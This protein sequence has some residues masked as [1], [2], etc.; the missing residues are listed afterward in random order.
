M[1]AIL[2][3]LATA[4]T[5]AL[6]ASCAAE[7]PRSLSEVTV[8]PNVAY[9]RDSGLALTMDVY[10]PARPNGAAVIWVN[11]GGFISGQIVQYESRPGPRY[12][13]LEAEEMVLI[14]QT[15]HIAL[16]E[17]FTFEN[18]LK[19]GFTVFDVCH[20]SSPRFNLGEITEHITRAVR[21][22][23]LRAT[24]FGI[25]PERIG[26][27]GAS[28]GGY[29][30]IYAGTAPDE[31]PVRSAG[32]T[33]TVSSHVQAVA[34]Y[35][36]AGYDFAS[37]VE[38][39]P[40]LLEALPT[41]D[42]DRDLLDSLSLKHHVSSGDPPLLIIYGD[43]DAPFITE[44]SAAVHADY[45]ALGL[46]SECV[47]IP[48][49]GHEFIREGSGYDVAVGKQANEKVATWLL[50]RLGNQDGAGDAAGS[51]SDTKRDGSSR[52]PRSASSAHRVASSP[53]ILLPWMKRSR[54]PAPCTRY[55]SWTPSA[56]YV[57]M[58]SLA[59][60]QGTGHPIHS[61]CAERCDDTSSSFDGNQWMGSISRASDPTPRWT[62]IRRPQARPRSPNCAKSR[63][64]GTIP[65]TPGP[66]REQAT[67]P[68]V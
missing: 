11:S 60:G 17:Q 56:R 26:I 3:V 4:A 5:L 30:A 9:G 15:E 6:L 33:G 65:P 37:D 28:S 42:I 13:F 16:L 20:G 66:D 2:A 21:V 46:A 29:L 24:E 61:L 45:R 53:A 19:E 52:P 12:R 59:K 32:L 23:R 51:S 48:G 44:P 18:L 63:T 67:P 27:F 62:P 47:V 22:I 55:S 58:G 40:V 31:Q 1:R 38:R 8:T 41:L 64:R 14:G 68:R 36:P 10:R 50:E 39:F 43:A 34:T 49:V 57:S 35:Y 7:T 54:S 25:D